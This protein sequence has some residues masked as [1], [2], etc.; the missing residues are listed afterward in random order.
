MS[1]LTLAG[2]AFVVCGTVAW[3]AGRIRLYQRDGMFT[4]S[5]PCYWIKDVMHHDQLWA[6]IDAACFAWFAWSWWNGGGGDDTKRRL[7]RWV[8]KFEGVRRTA[9]VGA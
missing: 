8:R 6:V 5:Y 3:I 9:P 2:S 4:L 1:A 7:R